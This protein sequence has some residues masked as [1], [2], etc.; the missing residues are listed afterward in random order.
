MQDKIIRLM[1]KER[2]T[3]IELLDIEKNNNL[4]VN[5]L[6]EKYSNGLRG[7]FLKSKTGEIV[8]VNENLPPAEQ[9]NVVKLILQGMQQCPSSEMGLVKDDMV[10]RCGGHCCFNM[11]G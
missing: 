11:N 9:A 10:F 4:F 1:P 2:Q 3:R 8:T 6:R 5:I 7:Y